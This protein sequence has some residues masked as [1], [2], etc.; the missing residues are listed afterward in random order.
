MMW[1]LFMDTFFNYLYAGLLFECPFKDELESCPFKKIREMV[2]KD[3]FK[4][5]NNYTKEYK[6]SIIKIHLDC[7]KNREALNLSGNNHFN[8]NIS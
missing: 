3:R 5:F 2:V 6:A 4:Y 8:Q 1:T 7:L